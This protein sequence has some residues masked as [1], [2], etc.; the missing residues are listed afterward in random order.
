ML[1]PKPSLLGR[2]IRSNSS[3]DGLSFANRYH[4]YSDLYQL[5]RRGAGR[6]GTESLAQDFANIDQ[7]TRQYCGAAFDS[8]SAVE[9]GFGTRP[10]RLIYFNA[11]GTNVRGIDLDQPLF[12]GKPHEVFRIVRGNGSLR[13]AK[14]FVRYWLFERQDCKDFEADLASSRPGFT[15]DSTRLIVADAGRPAAWN[16]LGQ[17]DVIYSFRVFEHLPQASLTSVIEQMHEHLKPSGLCY[18]IVTVYTGLIGG[19]LPEWYSSQ[20]H[21]LVRRSEPW[22][23]LRRRRFRADTYLN[24]YRRRDYAEL[25]STRFT[26]LKDEPLYPGLG[27]HFLSDTVRHEL[28]D[29]DEY[30]LLSNDVLFLLR[31]R[32]D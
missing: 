20:P 3:V 7:V 10:Y 19:H 17:A 22:E 23:H 24:E 1:C 21:D 18:I 11:R 8:L 31:H 4:Y 16:S 6:I 28:P 32:S 5:Y 29:L 2:N 13:A 14:S 15:F 12:A 27:V 9:I 25:F 30:E 26:I